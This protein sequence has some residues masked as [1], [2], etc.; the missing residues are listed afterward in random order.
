MSIHSELQG[1]SRIRRELEYIETKEFENHFFEVVFMNC[2]HKSCLNETIDLFLYM[3]E[4]G[5]NFEIVSST[6]NKKGSLLHLYFCETD[7]HIKDIVIK[8]FF[9]DQSAIGTH[10]LSLFN[11][12]LIAKY[13]L[14][15]ENSAKNYYNLS[16][17]LSWNEEL[18]L[19][20]LEEQRNIFSRKSATQALKGLHCYKKFLNDNLRELEKRFEEKKNNLL[21]SKGS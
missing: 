10:R 6:I 2:Y 12:F 20:N 19:E 9:N 1:V 21:L 14:L 16:E 5:N 15:D 18:I 4:K 8:N 3:E 13:N 7:T 11:S 17:L